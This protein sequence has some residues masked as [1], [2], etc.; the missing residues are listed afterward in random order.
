[1]ILSWLQC[2]ETIIIWVF[3]LFFFHLLCDI[4]KY[5][6][7]KEKK[8]LKIESNKINVKRM[9]IKSFKF[10]NDEYQ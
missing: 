5:Q 7:K 6:K 10:E 8:K 9:K 4:L 2:I 3:I 1:M